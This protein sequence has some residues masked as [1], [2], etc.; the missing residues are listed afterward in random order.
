[1]GRILNLPLKKEWY[2]MIESG[3]KKEEYREIKGYWIRKMIATIETGKEID[4][5]PREE[6]MAMLKEKESKNRLI[7]YTSVLFRY[8]YTKKTM[9]FKC[10]GI[11]IGIGNPKWGAP[12][13]EEVF[14]IKLGERIN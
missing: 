1:M 4:Q 8:G 5:H 11:S 6:N 13:D 9:E 14:I 2:D 10:E 3:E 12:K 7:K